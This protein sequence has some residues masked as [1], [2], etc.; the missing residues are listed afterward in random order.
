MKTTEPLVYII[1]LNYNGWKDTLECLASLEKLN[2]SNYKIIVIDNASQDD[3]VK[4]IR[5]HYPNLNLIVSKKNLGFAGANNLGIKEAQ[6]YGAKYVW[7]LNNDTVVDPYA[8]TA[9]VR[10]LEHD[11]AFGMCGSNLI[12][13]ANRDFLQAR[14]GG[15]YHKWTGA[16]FHVGEGEE[17]AKRINAQEVE[18]KL[19]YLVGASILV[20]LTLIE[21]IGLLPE[22]YFLYYEDVDWGLRAKAVS[23]LGY[24]PESKVYHKVG[25]SIGRTQD[26]QNS[27][28]RFRSEY[29]SVRSRLLLTRTFYPYALPSVYASLWLRVL[30]RLVKGEWIRVKTL[31]R[32]IWLLTSKG[33]SRELEPQS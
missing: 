12:Y 19:D 22:H 13:Y 18:D 9:M 33:L 15:T 16:T 28:K 25:S 31:T 3:S 32:V 8:L 24:A 27:E 5:Q 23:K 6:Y 11:V 30:I 10:K 2:Y 14:A 1:I 17:V 29:Y 20:R 26:Q 4:V 21:K 7:L